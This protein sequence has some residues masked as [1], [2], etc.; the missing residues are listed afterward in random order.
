MPADRV[1]SLYRDH[2]L[3]NPAVKYSRLPPAQNPSLPTAKD[4]FKMLCGPVPIN[5]VMQTTR[6][7]VAV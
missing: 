7:K 6:S 3:A 1:E 4:G 2:Q 5:K